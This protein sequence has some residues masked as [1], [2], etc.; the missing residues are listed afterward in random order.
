M[1]ETFAGLRA[2]ARVLIQNER[3]ELLLCRSRNGKAWVPPGGTLDAGET[4]AEAAA[5]E[6]VE[7]V[8][9]A[10]TVGDLV[11]LQEF[12]P[13][14]RVEHVLEVAFRAQAVADRPDDAIIAERGITPIGGAPNP[15]A[16]WQIQ[17]ID[18]PRRE[19]RWFTQAEV[20]ALLEPVYPGCLRANF[21]TGMPNPY[22]GLVE[23]T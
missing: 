15:W 22:L 19:V 23:G 16:A 5:R 8:G 7:E 3:G 17:D 2:V 14:Q 21:W 20:Q 4:L 1:G 11:Y 6:A 10:V 12:R 9:L 13:R 18:G